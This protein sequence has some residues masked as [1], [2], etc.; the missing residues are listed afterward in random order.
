[1]GGAEANHVSGTVDGESVFRDLGF[2]EAGTSDATARRYVETVK[3]ATKHGTMD[4]FA[5][6]QDGILRKITVNAQAD[7]VKS[8]PATK[9]TLTFTL[10]L[11][12]VNQPVKIDEP[13][14]ALPPASIA[15]IPRAK[16][17]S[18][19]DDILGTPSTSSRK[20]SA[21]PTKPHRAA[22]KHHAPAA[23]AR[24]KGRSAQA[25]VSCVQAAE[26]LAAL[27]HCQSLLP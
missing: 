4:V 26:D 21:T 2:Y 5:G 27:D 16:L 14:S 9:S 24:H 1:V 15:T 8:G 19:A 25:Y 12:K 11:D 23:K 7:P 3:T 22:P 6:K 10:G 13:K 18:E 20:T 17:G